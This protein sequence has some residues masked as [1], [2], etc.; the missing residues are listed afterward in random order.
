MLSERFV[1][2]NEDDQVLDENEF[3]ICSKFIRSSKECDIN[4]IKKISQVQ[5]QAK[6]DSQKAVAGDLIKLIH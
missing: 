3:Y 2:Q 1:K 5:Q 4:K 6:I